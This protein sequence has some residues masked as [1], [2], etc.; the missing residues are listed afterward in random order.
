MPV[1]PL[2]EHVVE[3]RQVGHS[4]ELLRRRFGIAAPSA[5]GEVRARWATL[6]G[7]P[8]AGKS[9]V[10]DLRDGTLR[11]RADDPAVAQR[12]RWDEARILAEVSPGDAV[13]VLSI[14]VSPLPHDP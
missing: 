14:R 6:V 3:P 1:D 4:V 13:R 5:L 8:L 10:I 12:L 11:V 2:P 7:D 9:E